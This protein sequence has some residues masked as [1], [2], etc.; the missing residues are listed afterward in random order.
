[1]F[2]LEKFLFVRRSVALDDMRNKARRNVRSV[3]I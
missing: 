1:V 3:M 2:I